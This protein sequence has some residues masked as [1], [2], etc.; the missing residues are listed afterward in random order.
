MSE[1]LFLILWEVLS[2]IF[3]FGFNLNPLYDGE[4]KYRRVSPCIVGMISAITC[5][6]AAIN[7]LP[8]VIFFICFILFFALIL[9]RVIFAMKSGKYSFRK[10]DK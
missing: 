3:V 6:S 10:T 2:E 4:N 1:F 9:L 8:F 5:A 7:V